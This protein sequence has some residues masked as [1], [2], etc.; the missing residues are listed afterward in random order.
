MSSYRRSFVVCHTS[1][2]TYCTCAFA[3]PLGSGKAP[4]AGY[5]LS[6]QG[7]FDFRRREKID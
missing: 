4:P 6:Q 5:V 3:G 1:L 7:D 2:Y